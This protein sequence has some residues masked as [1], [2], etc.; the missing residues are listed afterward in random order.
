M[1]IP[2]KKWMIGSSIILNAEISGCS[3]CGEGYETNYMGE[4]LAEKDMN[5]VY[6]E[7]L[8]PE[9][10]IIKRRSESIEAKI[11]FLYDRSVIDLK[12]ENNFHEIQRIEDSIK[13][14]INNKDLKIK[15]ISISGYA[16][17][18]G[19]T[20]YNMLLSAKRT[21][22]LL[23][24]IKQRVNGI[25]EELFHIENFGEDWDTF[26][27]KV[28]ASDNIPIEDK[29]SIINIVDRYKG[30]KDYCEKKFMSLIS[31]ET[32][33]Y[34]KS[35]IYPELRRD[36]YRIEYEVGDFTIDEGRRLINQYPNQLSVYEIHQIADSYESSSDD[37]MKCMLTGAHTYNNDII[38]LHNTALALL[39]RDKNN[40]VINLL[41][42]APRNGLLLN[43]LGIAYAKLGLFEKSI[44]VLQE[45][46]ELNNKIG[47]MN[48]NEVQKYIEYFSE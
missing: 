12:L 43:L 26:R 1:N 32:Y 44:L 7:K 11:K 9:K 34:I 5:L 28:I 33:Q 25:N 36:K 30:N 14:I 18:E 16:S 6:T 31:P 45:S 17:I 19:G 10:E 4:A 47:E 21:Q 13:A 3:E 48:Y 42:H 8:V 2:F 22:S 29:T 24:L 23:E 35:C 39:K 38:M 41:L 40:E 37:Y 27:E 20:E 46:K 15:N